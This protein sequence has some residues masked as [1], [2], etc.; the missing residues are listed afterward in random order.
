[1]DGAGNTVVHFYRAVN[2]YSK[3]E[4]VGGKKRGRKR[5]VENVASSFRRAARLTIRKDNFGPFDWQRVKRKEEKERKE[6][7]TRKEKASSISVPLYPVPSFSPL[8]GVSRNPSCQRTRGTEGCVF[9]RVE[10]QTAS[11]NMGK[12]RVNLI[13]ETNG[14]PRISR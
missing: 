6:E 2:V 3:Q 13:H 11:L 9:A 4:E 14:V 12:K 8:R 10:K 1:M 5:V 7:K